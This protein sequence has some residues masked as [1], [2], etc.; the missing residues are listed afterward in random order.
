[1]PQKPTLKRSSFLPRT[2]CTKT[3]RL[4]I[5]SK[6]KK[7]NLSFSEYQRQMLI[8][9]KV[10]VKQ[11]KNDTETVKQLLAIGNNLNQLT[12]GAHVEG[13]CDQTTLSKILNNIDEIVIKIV[14]DS[15]N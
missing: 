11:S 3:E 8:K 12:K 13:F 7:A 4:A 9:G 14:N 1:M 2:R 10:I 15:K 6:A 5:E